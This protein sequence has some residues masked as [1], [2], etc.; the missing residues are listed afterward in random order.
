VRC[1]VRNFILH[2]F[3][4]LRTLVIV[5]PSAN[6]FTLKACISVVYLM[7]HSKNTNSIMEQNP[8]SEA[9]SRSADEERLRLLRSLKAHYR[10]QNSPFLGPIVSHINPVHTSHPTSQR[11][12]STLNS[13][14]THVLQVISSLQVFHT[15]FS[16]YFS[17]LS[18]VLHVPPIQPP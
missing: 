3:S 12:S 11:S 2:Y 6:F 1:P 8:P 10:I 18:C 14:I 5:G 17:C 13:R 16:T 15:K 4:V 7:T 9:Y